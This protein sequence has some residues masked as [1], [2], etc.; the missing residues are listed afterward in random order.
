MMY[1]WIKALQT[2][3]VILGWLECYICRGFSMVRG[4][5]GRGSVKE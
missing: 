5:L 2:I 3:A 1:E 4:W